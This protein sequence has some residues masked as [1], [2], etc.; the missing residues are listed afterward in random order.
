M[1]LYLKFSDEAAA[2]A[3]LYDQVPVEFDTEGNVTKTEPRAKFRNIDT[4]GVISK[5]TGGTDEEPVF[6]ALDGWHV[7]VRVMDDEDSTLLETFVVYPETPIR[8]WG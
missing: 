1:D 8:V 6:T 2:K 4:I 3:A 7:N 5:R